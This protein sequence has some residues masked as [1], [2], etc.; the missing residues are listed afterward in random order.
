MA[1]FK[2]KPMNLIAAVDANYAIGKGND[3]PWRLPKEYAHFVRETTRTSE[4]NKINAVIMGRRCWESIPAKFRPLRDRVNVI[5]SRTMPREINL[6]KQLI[7]VPELEEA[8]QLLTEHEVFAPKIET[9]WNV[10]GKE[11]YRMGLSHPWTHKLVLTR[12]EAEFE[13]DVHFPEIPWE[14]FEPNSDFSADKK[15]EEKGISWYVTSYTC[16]STM[17]F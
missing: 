2:P 10:G 4:P 6:E 11:V 14:R 8:L 5:L 9:I 12:I 3:L 13:A 7:I 15:T 1:H 17:F 16:K